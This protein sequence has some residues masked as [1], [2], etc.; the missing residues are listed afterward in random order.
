[1]TS[2]QI[3]EWVA[4]IFHFI[5]FVLMAVCICLTVIDGVLARRADRAHPHLIRKA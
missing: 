4:P 5:A 1:V 3:T 2:F